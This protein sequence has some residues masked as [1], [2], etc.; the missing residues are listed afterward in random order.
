RGG[1]TGRR[2]AALAPARDE[3]RRGECQ[4][5]CQPTVGAHLARRILAR[6]APWERGPR[7]LLDRDL[8]VERRHATVTLR[9]VKRDRVFRPLLARVD[10]LGAELAVTPLR[11]GGTSSC[12]IA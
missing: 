9:A 3:Q 6:D 5:E 2:G 12:S 10:V 11:H 1:D 4:G 8:S 7:G